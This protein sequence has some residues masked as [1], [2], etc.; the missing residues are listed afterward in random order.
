MN[1]VNAVTLCTL[2]GALIGLGHTGWKDIGGLVWLEGF[3]VV[4]LILD[5]GEGLRSSLYLTVHCILTSTTYKLDFL[6]G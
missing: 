1:T 2:T 4:Y 5:F 3:A 6:K